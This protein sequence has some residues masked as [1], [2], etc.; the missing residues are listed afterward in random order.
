ML[1]PELPLSAVA[2][3]AERA[4]AAG[5]T[6]TLFMAGGEPRFDP[7]AMALRRLADDGPHSVQAITKYSPFRG[8]TDLLEGI[9]RKLAS[10]NGVRA[11]TEDLIVVPGGSAALFAV[12]SVLVSIDRPE[13]VITDPCWEHY[14]RIV[15]AASGR[16]VWARTVPSGAHNE[17]DLDALANLIGERTAAV[18]VNTPLNPT[19]S[20][21]SR[22]E[23][24]AV[25]EL[26]D[27]VGAYLVV[28][29]EYETFTYGGRRHVSARLGHPNAISLF[30]FS[31][32]F[33]LTG[34]RL[35]YVVAEATVID[36]LKRFGLYTWMYP[37][38]PSQAMA[39]AMRTEDLGDYLE[40]VRRLYAGKARRLST[41]LDAI[42][43]VDCPMPE[44]GVYVF[45][46]VADRRGDSLTYQLIDDQHLL[47]VPGE[48]AGRT[49]RGHVR[50]FV[51]LDDELLDEAV[52]RIRRCVDIERAPAGGEA[53]RA[54]T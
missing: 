27:R 43:Q 11:G 42:P 22:E 49:G 29:E 50:L 45:P 47:C 54:S 30:S 51:G 28:D 39:A 1:R 24:G 35:G 3:I 52:R 21:L 25:G 33:A 38:S 34:I 19:G 2:T 46:H 15:A 12:L 31:K 4:L 17:L 7:P 13:V 32:S 40:G 9:Q 53:V 26:C 41:A 6:D 16:P 18:L 8:H 14:P 36:A 44:G 48:A 20:M 5:W 37:P 23:I 10:I